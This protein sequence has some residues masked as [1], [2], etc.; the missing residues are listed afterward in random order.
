MTTKPSPSPPDGLP[1]EGVTPT[2][3]I[4]GLATAVRNLVSSAAERAK[5]ER[6]CEQELLFH[7]GNRERAGACANEG[8]KQPGLHS[9]SVAE[10]HRGSTGLPR[11]FRREF[12]G[13]GT[14]RP[15]AQPGPRATIKRTRWF[16]DR[17]R[18]PRNG[19]RQ[20]DR[21]IDRDLCG[22]IAN[23]WIANIPRMTRLRSPPD[24]TIFKYAVT[25]SPADGK[26]NVHW[27][28]APQSA[29]DATTAREARAFLRLENIMVG[30]INDVKWTVRSMERGSAKA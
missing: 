30:S 22:R 28:R 25:W 3:M 1:P 24:R 18:R 29:M 13:A 26:R 23:A 2:S 20:R 6:L 14:G 9:A 5:S 12:D 17:R 4:F 15:D 7:S 11:N 21:R 16:D 19:G 27:A 8:R 10:S